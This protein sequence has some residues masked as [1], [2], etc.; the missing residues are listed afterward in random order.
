MAAVTVW[1]AAESAA[2][3][4]SEAT[5]GSVPG[6]L[7]PQVHAETAAEAGAQGAGLELQLAGGEGLVLHGHGAVAA[8]HG[9][10]QR[11]VPGVGLLVPLVHRH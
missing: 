3:R 2:G 11:P 6:L 8:Q 1:S 9:D 5:A 4:R 10:A 7:L